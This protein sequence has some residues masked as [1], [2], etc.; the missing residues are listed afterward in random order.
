MTIYTV[1]DN[2]H[3][4]ITQGGSMSF[5]KPEDKFFLVKVFFIGFFVI[6]LSKVFSSIPPLYDHY[7]IVTILTLLLKESGIAIMIASVL[8]YT[9]EEVARAKQLK[10]IENFSLKVGEDVLSAVFKKIVPDSIFNEI[11]HSVLEQTI[12]KRDACLTYV[13]SELN[14]DDIKKLELAN[15]ESQSYLRCELSTRHKLINLSDAPAIGHLIKNGI[16]C[17]LNSNMSKHLEIHSAFIRH[18]LTAEELKKKTNKLENGVI[19][20]EYQTTLASQEELDIC[21]CSTTYKKIDD[22]E[23]WTTLVPTENMSLDVTFPNGFIID[24]RA[25]HSKALVKGHGNENTNR[26]IFD[27]K[28]GIFPHQGITFW[29]RKT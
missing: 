20:F 27:L 22:T 7:Y 24:A 26:V 25:N 6:A 29:W 28:H 1:I 13:L 19:S 14:Q 5:W 18:K 2:T 9:V 11:K 16:S 3:K 21:F 12:I 8:G 10:E 15:E 23:V 4:I 17:D